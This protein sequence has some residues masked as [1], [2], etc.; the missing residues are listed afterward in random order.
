MYVCVCV[1]VYR[2]GTIAGT[3]PAVP[4]A[5]GKGAHRPESENSH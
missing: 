1:Q 2:D 5:D 3:G 4:K